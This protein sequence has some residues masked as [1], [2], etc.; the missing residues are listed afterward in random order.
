MTITKTVLSLLL[1]TSALFAETI[2]STDSN[3]STRIKFWQ[4]QKVFSWDGLNIRAY[5]DYEKKKI[6]QIPHNAKCIVNHGC[7]K[8][9]DFQTM[10]NMQE[11][12]IEAFLG[13]AAEQWCYIDYDG[14]SGWVNSYYLKESTS[15]CQ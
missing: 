11:G 4:V 5:S 10:G 12:E 6:G 7:G 3:S 8:D 15:Q 2:E 14:I 1:L 9:I 13:Q